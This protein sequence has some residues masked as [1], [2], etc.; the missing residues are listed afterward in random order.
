M[1]AMMKL[2]IQFE[3]APIDVPL[4]RIESGKISAQNFSTLLKISYR[5]ICVPEISTQLA[6][7]HE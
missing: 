4:A 2:F 7:P 1:N 3:D 6:G 5:G